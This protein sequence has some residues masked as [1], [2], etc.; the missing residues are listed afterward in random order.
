MN[1]TFDEFR[2]IIQ[3]HRS[4][5]ADAYFQETFNAF[6]KNADGFITAKEIKNSPRIFCCGSSYPSPP[7][8]TSL[9]PN[10]DMPLVAS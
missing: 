9:T 6:D 5:T 3:E 10:D 1:I 4:P 7:T 8:L 2:Q